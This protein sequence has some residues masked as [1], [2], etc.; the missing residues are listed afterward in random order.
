M[1]PC[2]H[3]STGAGNPKPETRMTN[4]AIKPE[5]PNDQT[6]ALGHSG[7]GDWALFRISGFGLRVLIQLAPR[8]PRG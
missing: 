5:C 3:D 1:R 6:A 7:I 2:A 8:R 4:Q